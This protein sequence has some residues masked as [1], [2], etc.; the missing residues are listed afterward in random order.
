MIKTQIGNPD[1]ESA[2]D[3]DSFTKRSGGSKAEYD[4]L[5]RLYESTL[6]PMP[7]NG[8]IVNAVFQGKSAEYFIFSMYGLKDDIRIDDKVS[9]YKYLKNTQKEF[10]TIRN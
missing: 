10:E 8:D 5:C 1:L 4:D 3:D 9:E 2:F 7:K 6:V